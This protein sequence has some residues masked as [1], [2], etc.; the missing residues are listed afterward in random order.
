MEPVLWVLGLNPFRAQPTSSA[1]FF[2]LSWIPTL[3][4]CTKIFAGSRGGG[5]H[6]NLAYLGNKRLLFLSYARKFKEGICCCGSAAQ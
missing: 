2:P 1:D 3:G 4:L 6:I 5:Y